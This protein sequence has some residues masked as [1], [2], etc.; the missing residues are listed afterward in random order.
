MSLQLAFWLG[1][2]Q[3]VAE[4]FP[5]SSLGLLTVAPHVFGV[6]FHLSGAAYLPFVVAV[7]VGTALALALYFRQTW[8][9]LI[10]GGLHWL[11]GRR[12]PAARQLGLVVAGTIPA[13]IVGL[14]ARHGLAPLFAEPRV[15]ALLLCANAGLLFL[16]ER[17]RR[18]SRSSRRLEQLSA[19]QACR[20]GVWQMFALL[21]GLSR[22]GLSLAGGLRQG[23]RLDEAARF[24]FLM[25]TPLILAAGLVEL[26][27]LLH[28]SSAGLRL[29]ALVGGLTAGG[30]AWHSTHWLLRWFRHGG[31][32]RLAW[33]A[34]ALGV[35]AL[36]AVR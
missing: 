2:V 35:A 11:N 5:F 21:P 32:T 15:A 6:P 18:Q 3:G 25:A 19:A 28:A 33:V 14:V 29:P 10:G 9:E 17:W 27:R 36:V 23:L 12:D 20:V 8:V 26:P 13:G 4:L 22:S 31:L 30:A 34:L 16:A 24:A 1:L 7:H